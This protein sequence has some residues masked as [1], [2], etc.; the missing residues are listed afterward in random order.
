MLLASCVSSSSVVCED[1]SSCPGGFQCDVENHRCL[2]P[3]QVA[4]CDGK[5]EGDDCEFNGGPGACRDGACEIFFCGDGYVTAGEE[6]DG[7]DLGTDEMGNPPDC[8]SFG[9]YGVEGLAC[10]PSCIYDLSVCYELHGYCGDMLVN[11][12][13]LCDGSTAKTCMSIG[14][15]AGAVTC[16]QS[17][18]LGIR[19]CNRFGWTAESLADTVAQAVAGTGPD[20]QWA[21]GTKGRAMHYEGAFWNMVPTGVQ[22]TLINGW[23]IA[24]ND[25]WAVG[26]SRASPPLPSIVLHWNGSVWSAVSGAPVGAEFL[27]VW[28]A[29]AAAVYFATEADGVQL[30][31]GSAWSEVGTL[32]GKPTKLRGTGPNDIWAAIEGGVL[33][34][35]NGATWSPTTL[36]G[37]NVQFIDANAPNDVWV[38][39]PSLANP[40][41][42]VIAHYDGSGWTQ[43]VTAQE[44]YNAIASSAPNDTWVAGVDGIMRHWDGVAWSRTTNIGAS[45]SGLA[46]LSGMISFGPGDVTAVSTLNLAYRYRGQTFGLFA[47]LGPNPFDATQNLAIWGRDA[48]D[49]YVTNVRGEVWHN[50]SSGWVLAY[51]IPQGINTIL[52]RAVWGSGPSD[53]YVAGSDGRVYHYDGMMWAG[54]DL[55][56]GV[57]LHEL[58]GSGA[59][60]VWAFGT[61]GAFRRVSATMWTRYAL[62]DRRVLGVSGTGPSDIWVVE[63]GTPNTLWH[64]NGSAWATV[65]T[66]A[67]FPMIAVVAVAPDDVHVSEEQGRMLHF[68]GTEWTETILAPLADLKFLAATA[69]DDV[70]AGSERD[71]YHYN[72]EIW[73]PMRPPIEFVPNTSDYIPM[74]DLQAVPGRVDMLLQRYRI[75]TLIRT[76]PISCAVREVCGDA[77]DNDCDNL[78]DRVDTSECP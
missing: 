17:C 19:N 52:A 35:W 70:I 51:T 48:N 78:L 76:R 74:I 55:S 3:E 9:F 29:S 38:I 1:G 16:D 73:S 41:T 23:A 11:G 25:V 60:D 68:N 30:Y 2:L 12:P 65:A 27:D 54:E 13:E 77:V 20:D 58:W 57:P 32:T 44:T 47:P 5:A 36:A 66:G 59:S 72:G 33:Q 69:A 18:G 46:A 31:T 6:C 24:P 49:L 71:L 42:G 26:Q 75:R 50:T 10:R 14:F 39:G 7:D 8:K 63:E 15:D 40:S 21:F 37:V 28:A 22:Q 53:V 62:S 64:W 45:P 34:H 43:W 61:A 4:A 56:P 67:S